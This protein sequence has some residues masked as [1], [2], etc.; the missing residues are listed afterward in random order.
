MIIVLVAIAAVGS[1]K[2]SSG[3]KNNSGS[4]TRE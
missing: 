2:G 4:V 1:G 3:G